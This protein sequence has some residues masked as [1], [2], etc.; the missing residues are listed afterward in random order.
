VIKFLL[1]LKGNFAQDYAASIEGTEV[2]IW[3]RNG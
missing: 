2:K 3:S 1:T